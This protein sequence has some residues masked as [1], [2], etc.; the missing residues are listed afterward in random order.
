MSLTITEALA[1]IKT[2]SKRITTKKNFVLTYI[3]RADGFKDPLHGDGGSFEALR[4]ERQAIDDLEQRLVA[5]RRGIQKANDATMVTLEGIEMSIADWLVW[6]RDVLPT[7]KDYL[8]EIRQKL[9][10]TRDQAKRSGQNL[11]TQGQ[12]AVTPSDVIININEQDLA[13]DIEMLVNIEGQLDGQLSLKN[14]TTQIVE[15]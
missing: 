11:V 13:K 1:E 9:S 7:R 4:R 3:A 2:I 5:L 6:R 15:V 14:A 12:Q 10:A 8:N